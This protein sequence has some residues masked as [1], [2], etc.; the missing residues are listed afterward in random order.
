MSETKAYSPDVLD[1]TEPFY[2]AGHRGL[3]GSAIWRRLES[4][5]FTNLVGRTSTQLDLKDRDMVFAFFAE[6]E[7]RYV[8]LAAAKVGGILANNSYP[9]DFLSE[10]LLIQVNVMDAAVAHG[11]ERLRLL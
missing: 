1:R 5:G 4:E 11:T 3:V 10:N 7:P 6:A 8:V 2:V 9:V